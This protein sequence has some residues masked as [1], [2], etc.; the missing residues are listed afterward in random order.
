MAD[1]KEKRY[2]SERAALYFSRRSR[3]G[4]IPFYILAALVCALFAW[5]N[6]RAGKSSAYFIVAAVFFLIAMWQYGYAKT[7]DVSPDEADGRFDVVREQIDLVKA[8]ATASE[9]YLEAFMPLEKH[10][11]AAYTPDSIGETEPLLRAD[12]TDHIG[13]ST[14]IQQSCLSFGKS[15]LIAFSYIRSITDEKEESDNSILPYDKISNVHIEKREIPCPLE[16][17]GKETENRS[18]PAIFLKNSKTGEDFSFAFSEAEGADAESFI[19]RLKA[20]INEQ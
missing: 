20:R 6:M 9:M 14:H 8:A 15:S 4:T 2:E 7:A 13:R 16:P 10:T 17:E 12:K 18:F 1:K 5:M 11:F 19:E 3:R